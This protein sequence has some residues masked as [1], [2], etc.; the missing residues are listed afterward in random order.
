MHLENALSLV[1]GLTLTLPCVESRSHLE[2][3]PQFFFIFSLCFHTE[4][5]EIS[6]VL[7]T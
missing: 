2:C 4:M 3:H 7:F 5:P 1:P 6:L